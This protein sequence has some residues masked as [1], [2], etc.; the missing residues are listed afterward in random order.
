MR[1]QLSS[2]VEAALRSARPVVALESSVIAQGLP[3]PQNMESALRCEQAVREGGAVPGT[4]A[5]LDGEICVGLSEPQLRRLSTEQG[6]LKVAS[7]DLAV[8]VA[9]LRTGGTT[10]SATC[11][12]AARAGIAVFATGGIGGV[13]RGAPE[14][15]DVSQDLWA[16]SR[17]PVAVVCAGAKSVLDLAWTLEALEALAV[18]V[19]GLGTSQ[20]PSFYSRES[21]LPLEH[22]A[23]DPGMAA[24]I[25]HARLELGQG[26]LVIA[27]PPPSQTALPQAEVEEHLARALAAAR[28]GNIQ[29]K[30]VT[31]FLL[32]ELAS[33]TGGRT[34]TAN[35]ALLQNNA[36]LAAAVACALGALRARPS[37]PP[38][39]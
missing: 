28:A 19:V 5:V 32:G 21:G 18:P 30:A 31:P 20:L 35:L 14:D 9:T 33:R 24:R 22:S 29:G 26:G 36:R 39:R 3:R 17:F 34:L 10:V 15:L 16:L 4:I 13:H 11:E 23:A 7:R 6:L 8:A 1:L 2:E 25:I 37:P 12:I 27:A 38:G